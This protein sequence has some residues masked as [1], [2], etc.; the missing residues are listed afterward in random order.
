LYI[1]LRQQQQQLRPCNDWIIGFATSNENEIKNAT[2]MNGWIDR[3]SSSSSSKSIVSSRA[4]TI[5]T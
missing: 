5:N 3:S 4:I 2:G 1:L